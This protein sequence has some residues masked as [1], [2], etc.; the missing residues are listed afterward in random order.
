MVF[1]AE[2]TDEERDRW[3]ERMAEEVVRRRMETPAVMALEMH[4]PLAFLG[5]QAVI[6]ATPF[7]APFVGPEN[8][9]KFSRLM[10]ER[11]N[12]E[13]LIDRIEVLSAK[14]KAS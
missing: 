2:L 3:L 1:D 5:S 14:S 10:Q 4:R 9:L 11:G 12:I 7:I 8:V 6:V 13:R